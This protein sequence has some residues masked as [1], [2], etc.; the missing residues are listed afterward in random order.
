MLTPRS[1][2]LVAKLDEKRAAVVSPLLSLDMGTAQSVDYVI[3]SS[4]LRYH[5]AFRTGQAASVH[6]R[7]LQNGII[8][9]SSIKT[10]DFTYVEWHCAQV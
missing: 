5:H 7:K 6:T 2:R 10:S 8:D 4:L 3:G 9:E 1:R